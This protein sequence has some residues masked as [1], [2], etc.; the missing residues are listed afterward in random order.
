[1]NP[2]LLSFHLFV[3]VL[4]VAALGVVVTWVWERWFDLLDWASRRAMVRKFRAADR[5]LPVSLARFEN[6]R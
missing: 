2:W 4:C 5:P 1:M 6:A 3:L